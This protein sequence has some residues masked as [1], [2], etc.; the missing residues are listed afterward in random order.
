MKGTFLILVSLLMIFATSCKSS[1]GISAD[2]PRCIYDEIANNQ[3]KADWMIGRVEEYQFQDKLVYAFQPD[4][5]KIADGATTI[6]DANC[7]TLC[8]V[9]GFGG[10]SVNSCNGENFFQSAILKRIIWKKK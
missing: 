3:K 4:E 2:T 5:K 7:T 6:K 9:G 8:H 10:P 1:Y